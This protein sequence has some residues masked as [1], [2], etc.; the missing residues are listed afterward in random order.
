MKQQT[1]PDK[2]TPYGAPLQGSNRSY[3]TRIGTTD[4]RQAEFDSGEWQTVSGGFR[5]YLHSI[6]LIYSNILHVIR[7]N[8]VL[9]QKN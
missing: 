3:G 7:N 5:M 2:N 1:Q 4:I 6:L 8:D 9:M